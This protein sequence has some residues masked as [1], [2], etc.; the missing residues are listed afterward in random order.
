MMNY[1]F[2][3]LVV[4][5]FIS[6]AATGSMSELSAAVIEGGTNAVELLIR[7]VSMLCLW[8]GIMEIADKGYFKIAFTLDKAYFSPYPK[9]KGC[10]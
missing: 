4:L 10:P 3:V 7:L 5:S 2:P 6:A 8:G 9:G 1:V